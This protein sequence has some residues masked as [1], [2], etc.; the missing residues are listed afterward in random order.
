MLN[1]QR[2]LGKWDELHSLVKIWRTFWDDIS[3]FVQCRAIEGPD[4]LEAIGWYNVVDHLVL[5]WLSTWC[6]KKEDE[7]LPWDIQNFLDRSM[8]PPSLEGSKNWRRTYPCQSRFEKNRG[9]KEFGKQ[10]STSTTQTTAMKPIGRVDTWRS[11][12]GKTVFWVVNL[13]GLIIDGHLDD[14]LKLS[15]EDVL[16]QRL[17]AQAYYKGLHHPSGKDGNSWP[18]AMICIDQNDY[19]LTCGKSWRRR[20]DSIPSQSPLNDENHIIRQTISMRSMLNMLLKVDPNLLGQTHIVKLQEM[21]QQQKI[22]F[23]EMMMTRKQSSTFTLLTITSYWQLLDLIG[24]KLSLP[25][26]QQVVNQ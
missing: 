12:D 6:A 20:H 25:V 5:V 2:D 1:R 24:T 14:I 16:N 15:V 10:K 11:L 7:A 18:F 9:M 4:M 21:H 3:R 8:I 13:K 23:L 26:L 17:Q 22:R 19:S